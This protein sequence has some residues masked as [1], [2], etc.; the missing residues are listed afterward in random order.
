MSCCKQEPF[1]AFLG[2][3]GVNW[4][5]IGQLEFLVGSGPLALSVVVWDLAL[6][7][8]AGGECPEVWES[9]GGEGRVWAPI[10]WFAFEKCLF[11]Q[12]IR[13]RG[14]WCNWIPLNAKLRQFVG[15]W[16]IDDKLLYSFMCYF[17]LSSCHAWKCAQVPH[18]GMHRTRPCEQ[19]PQ[20]AQE[21]I[22][23]RLERNFPPRKQGT[24]RVLSKLLDQHQ[25]C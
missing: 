20:H 7:V 8:R 16:C 15:V 4:P 17:V 6:G 24:C 11:S 14:G 22:G 3:S 10:G 9:E 18:P 21:V 2:G 5:Q 25:I 12:R 1:W 13:E 19:Q 23:M